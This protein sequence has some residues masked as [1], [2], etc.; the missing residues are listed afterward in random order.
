MRSD[1]YI[2]WCNENEGR[3]YPIRE[4]ASRKT[5]E[6]TIL[7]ND[8]IADLGIMVPSQYA[9]LYI[10]SVAVTPALISIAISSSTAG[11]LLLGTYA[12]AGLKPYAAY[13]LEPM[14]DNVSGWVVFGNH[15]A[16]EREYYRFGS[17][18]QTGLEERVVNVIRPPTVQRFQ[19]LG[20]ND[21]IYA[22]NI[23]ELKAGT[24]FIVERDPED[25]QN[26]II[27]LNPEL[28]GRFLGPCRTEPSVAAC[29]VPIIRRVNGVTADENGV[30]TL[31]FE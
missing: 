22:T 13:P 27:R 21:S 23:V 24:A 8:V 2:Q 17:A 11:G 10:S 18:T 3:A 25:A 20:N 16:T 5:A 1:S 26:I 31:R 7:P 29:G 19:R 4:E 12:R 6:G 28:A 9:S 30:L 15:I 14:R